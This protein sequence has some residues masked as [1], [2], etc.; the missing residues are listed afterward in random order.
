[1]VPVGKDVLLSVQVAIK[2]FNM[3][4]VL[5]P[6]NPHCFLTITELTRLGDTKI[7]IKAIV[8]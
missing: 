8:S 5:T 2:I 3:F 7:A 1:M 6:Y 4:L